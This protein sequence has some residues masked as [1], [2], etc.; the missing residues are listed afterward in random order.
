MA[1]LRDLV[2]AVAIG[3]IPLAAP[4][5]A[6][7]V[8][9]RAEDIAAASARFGIDRQWVEAVM[10]AES[11]G[12]TVW[13]GRPI[14]SAAGA[15]GLMQLMPGTWAD[16]RRL[17]GL[18]QNPHDPHDNIVAGTAYLAAMNRRFGYP[19]LFGAY[20]A[21]PAR[22]RQF[23]LE[24]RP[25]PPETRAYMTG[26]TASLGMEWAAP[27]TRP[28]AKNPPSLF[29]YRVEKPELATEESGRDGVAKTDSL[30]AVRRTF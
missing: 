11:G 22:Y 14:T 23:L 8:A 10:R 17:H 1:T 9:A 28:P 13:R 27:Q 25:L 19:G 5:H 6:D 12:R 21:G 16:M 20:H 18:G 26:I 4:L 2:L 3:L 7:P 30:F 15:M 29:L 24:G